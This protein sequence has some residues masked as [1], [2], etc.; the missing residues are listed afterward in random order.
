MEKI[1]AALRV[2]EDSGPA[3][4]L[5]DIH[6]DQM[7]GIGLGSGT[8]SIDGPSFGD[9]VDRLAGTDPE[10]SAEVPPAGDRVQEVAGVHPFA[11]LTEGDLPHPVAVEGVGDV[12]IGTHDLEMRLG[13]VEE[14]PEIG[15]GPGKIRQHLTRRYS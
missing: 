4:K 2:A 3:L 7:D 5:L 14:P 10:K 13:V 11:P 6:A 12:E 15:L 1:D 8:A 9:D